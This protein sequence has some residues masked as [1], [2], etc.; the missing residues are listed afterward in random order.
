LVLFEAFIMIRPGI[1]HLGHI[2]VV[3]SNPSIKNTRHDLEEVKNNK[4]GVCKTGG[5]KEF[6][7]G[8]QPCKEN[9][10]RSKQQMLQAFEFI[11]T[12]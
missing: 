11:R 2:A 3:D 7:F 12:K 6:Y 9:E 10:V 8:N 4:L 5:F 1:N